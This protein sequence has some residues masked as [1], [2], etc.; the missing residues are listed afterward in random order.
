VLNYL[1]AWRYGL[2]TSSSLQKK[3]VSFWNNIE[4][5]FYIGFLK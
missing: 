1:F 5:K 4:I 3:L 2:Y